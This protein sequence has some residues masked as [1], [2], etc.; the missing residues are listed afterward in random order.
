MDVGRAPDQIPSLTLASRQD[1]TATPYAPAHP[2]AIEHQAFD[3][4]N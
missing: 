1:V 4:L 2:E 3:T